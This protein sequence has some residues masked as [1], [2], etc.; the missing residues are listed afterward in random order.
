MYESY[1]LRAV[2]PD[3]SQGVWIRHTVHKR[4]GAAPTGSVWITVWDGG[5][6]PVAHKETS[7]ALSAPDGAWIDVGG[8][9][10]G[11]AGA[12]G[13]CGPASWSLRFTP[14]APMLRH[15]RRRVL[16]RAPIPRTKLTSPAPLAS[17]D[18]T[19]RFGGNTLAL[20]G[21]SGMV[22]H[23][24]GA[25]HAER[26]VWLHGVDFAEDPDAWVDVAIGRILVAGRLTPWVANGALAFGGR[27]YVLG[28]LFARGTK[29]Q[30]QVGH[31]D[32][33]IPSPDG[34]T[35]AATVEAPPASTIG[36]RY[37]DP[38]GGEHDVANCS[39]AGLTLAV[40]GHTLHTPHGAA[41]ELGMRERDHGRA[42]AVRGRMS[43]QR[44][45]VAHAWTG[46]SSPALGPF[47]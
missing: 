41:Y 37:A 45:A 2:A 44:S 20:D 33:V 32:L 27:T 12:Q 22:G 47:S 40:D 34:I 7:D 6:P 30:A 14:R 28:G 11:P 17:F 13:A 31:A 15:L 25:E 24:W 9:S 38:D 39:V 43:A 18:G 46:A 42:A 8:S 29:V 23:N 21:W 16:Y 10:F 35:A 5:G 4:P 26:W 19:V 36:W 1:Y 3:E